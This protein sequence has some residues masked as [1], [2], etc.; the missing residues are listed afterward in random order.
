MLAHWVLR[1]IPQ[2]KEITFIPSICQ[3]KALFTYCAPLLANLC[4]YLYEVEFLRSMK[5]SNKRSVSITQGLNNSSEISA[6]M[7]VWS[8]GHQSREMLCHTW[9]Y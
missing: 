9:I 7:R 6:L 2:S 4:L 1:K 5:K 8:Q 3:S